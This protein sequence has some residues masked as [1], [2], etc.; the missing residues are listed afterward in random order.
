L[1]FFVITP[2]PGC[3][4]FSPQVSTFLWIPGFKTFWFLSPLGVSGA[5]LSHPP[6]RLVLSVSP[7]HVPFFGLPTSAAFSLGPLPGF[8]HYQKNVF[9]KFLQI[10]SSGVFYHPKN[11]WKTGWIW[12]SQP[13][14]KNWCFLLQQMSPYPTE[15]GDR[16]P[17][18]CAFFHPTWFSARTS[19]MA[20]GPP[21]APQPP[22]TLIAV[23]HLPHWLV[24]PTFKKVGA[25][26]QFPPQPPP[27]QR[28][29]P[30]PHPHLRLSN[31]VVY[32]FPRGFFFVV[33]W[34]TPLAVLSP[35]PCVPFLPF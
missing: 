5:F 11:N 17:P 27:T 13:P 29:P 26:F 12:Q 24:P 23:F 31:S 25:T 3:N 30:P 35:A 34:H 28:S 22:K 14:I 9:V 1:F 7:D 6:L 20:G 15:T 32:E 2:T 8:L 10:F 19:W 16:P 4:P 18:W 21:G 33:F